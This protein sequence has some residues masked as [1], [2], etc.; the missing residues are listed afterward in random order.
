MIALSWYSVSQ[1]ASVAHGI[2]QSLQDSAHVFE[3]AVGAH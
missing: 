3:A 2:L 1:A